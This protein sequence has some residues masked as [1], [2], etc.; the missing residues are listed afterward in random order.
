MEQTDEMKI[1]A[2][3]SQ[4]RVDDESIKIVQYIHFLIYIFTLD[5]PWLD[6]E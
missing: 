6:P 4:S 2:G 5:F 1:S 3:L